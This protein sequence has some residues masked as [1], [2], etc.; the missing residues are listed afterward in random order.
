[1]PATK[2]PAAKRETTA[3][4][5]RRLGAESVAKKPAAARVA[6]KKPVKADAPALAEPRVSAERLA[7]A[8]FVVKTRAGKGG[9]K[10]AWSAVADAV[11]KREGTRPTGS[12][13]RRLFYLGGGERVRA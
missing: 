9:T 13:L 3:E 12:Q 4:R 1:M 6:G 7:L 2:K 5:R 10:A 11:E 8:K